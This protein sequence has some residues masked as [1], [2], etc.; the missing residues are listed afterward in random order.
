M[1]NFDLVVENVVNQYKPL[2]RTFVI[3]LL[4]DSQVD[5]ENYVKL[6]DVP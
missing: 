2:M 5:L 3:C 6:L 4:L 1:L